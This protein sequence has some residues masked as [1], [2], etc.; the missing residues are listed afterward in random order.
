M[1]DLIPF[2]TATLPAHLKNSRFQ[3]TNDLVSGEGF[4]AISV[5]G[6]VFTRVMGETRDLITAPGTDDEPARS[7]EVVVVNYNKNRSKVYY[8][9]T[10]TEGSDAKP[11]C[12]SN[13]GIGPAADA[14]GPQAKKC[15]TCPHNQWGSRIT[16]SG[17]KAK[18][19]ADSIR[20]AVAPAGQLNDPMLLRVPATSIKALSQYQDLLYKRGVAVQQVVTKIGFDYS[21]AYPSLTFKPVGFLSDAM[22]DEVEAM[23]ESSVVMS[24]IGTAPVA[25]PAELP[26]ETAPA[27]KPVAK[28]PAKVVVED[29]EPEEAPAPKP[30]KKKA[31]VVV[32]EDDDDE[33]EAAPKPVAKKKAAPVVE[34][35]DDLVG[36]LDDLLEDDDDFAA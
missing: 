11:T 22:M 36:A 12:Y 26:F 2:N 34:V 16:D 14:T 30:A 33:V 6:K 24:I 10:Y 28:K 20:L 9:T 4:P 3:P 25:P 7:L 21:V 27:P 13:D 19:C 1:S 18:A 31:K 32:E 8:E 23:F 35:D 5:K 15:S 29:D 17:S